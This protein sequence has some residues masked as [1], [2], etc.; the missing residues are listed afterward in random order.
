MILVLSWMHDDGPGGRGSGLSRHQAVWR[1][2]G[3]NGRKP[4]SSFPR[5]SGL[6]KPKASLAGP[7]SQPPTMI[8][9]RDADRPTSVSL[10]NIYG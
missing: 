8:T 1:Y 2:Y 6:Q 10:P 9:Q 5:P 7:T 3:A 4:S